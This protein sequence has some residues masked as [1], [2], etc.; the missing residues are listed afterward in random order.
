MGAVVAE[1]EVLLYGVHYPI[2]RP[3]RPQ[4]APNFGTRIVIGDTTRS[5]QTLVSEW[6]MSDWRGGMGVY[7]IDEKTQPDRYWTGTALA[8]FKKQLTLP[9]RAVDTG[10]GDAAGT[11][12]V[13][14][15]VE[16]EGNLYAAFDTLVQQYNNTTELWAT[17]RTL[18]ASPTSAIVWDGNM[19][20]FTG[21]QYDYSADG[22]TWSRVNIPGRYACIFDNRLVTIDNNGRI[23]YTLDGV[24]WFHNAQL[25]LPAGEYT[26]LV[27]FPNV[28]GEPALWV[29]TRSGVYVVDFWTEAVYDTVLKYAPSD[30]GGSMYPW[31]DGYLYV[32]DGLPIHRFNGATTAPVGLDRDDG[33]PADLRGGIAGFTASPNWLVGILDATAVGVASPTIAYH[34]Q[35]WGDTFVDRRLG[36]SAILA[37][38]GI[39]WHI[40]YQSGDL[41]RGT[42]WALFSTIH[43]EQRLWFGADGV[44]RYI[45]IPEGVYDPLL[46]TGAR[47]DSPAEHITGWFDAGFSEITKL[48]I[49]LKLRG[50]S[51]GSIGSAD[52]RIEVYYGLDDDDTWTLLTT[53]T[54][55]VPDEIS[56]AAGAGT[57]FQKI[58]FRFLLYSSSTSITPALLFASLRF[59]KL[60]KVLRAWTFQVDCTKEYRGRSPEELIRG[61]WQ[62]GQGYGPD[63]TAQSLGEFTFRDGRDTAQSFR[64]RVSGMSGQEWTGSEEK[65]VYDVTVVSA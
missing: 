14:A 62:A 21:D 18:A 34:G 63:D 31:R 36:Y 26:S 42:R 19:Y 3:V 52:P 6:I 59:W 45:V 32:A 50:L 58:R 46:D 15:G 4:L 53:M 39:G 29:G 51:L 55:N 20:W 27:V 12:V 57:P 28:A 44:A 7:E 56:F 10:K 25:P 22:T 49:S 64:V 8:L 60:P 2:T 54:A 41:N 1:N 65:A 11:P 13:Y 24:S 35:P 5:D 17:S 37:W 33:L 43:N 38:T 47:Y 23:R 61:L 40:L 48:A 16:F 30:F 9:L